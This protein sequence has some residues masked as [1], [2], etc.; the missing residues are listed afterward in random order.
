MKLNFVAIPFAALLVLLSGCGQVGATSDGGSS[1]SEG[2]AATSSAAPTS[3]GDI[4]LVPVKDPT[5]GAFTIDMPKGWKNLA[6]VARAYDQVTSVVNSVSPDGSVII[7]SGDP[8]IPIYFKTNSPTVEVAR[9]QEKVNPKIKV[10]DYI[11]AESY[12]PDY[13]TKKF[14]KLPGFEIVKTEPNADL[15]AAAIE[16][17]QKGGYNFPLETVVVHF[18]Y[19]EDGTKRNA[20]L[21]GATS[22][23]GSGWIVMC[24]GISTTGNPMDYLPVYLKMGRSS[25]TDEGWKQKQQ[26]L[27]EQRM[28][29]LKQAH[30]QQLGRWAEMNNQHQQRM[31]AIKA[32]GDA[33][34]KS[35]YERDAASDRSHRNFLNMI[36]EES[37]VVTSDGTRHQVS[38]SYD[39]YY[40]HKRTGKYIGGDV[41]FN[42]DSI[43]RMGLNPDDYEQAKVTR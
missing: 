9:F 23:M 11:P 20:I 22:D 39:N 21:L 26:A 36:N 8:A 30:Q 15:Q 33:S 4:E 40:L 13:V 38:N 5:E 24:G 17:M 14:G 10:A 12:F 31:A 34:M 3:P 16:N 6:Y 35:Y 29:A 43:R 41:H 27:H 2:G 42:E 1:P 25:V 7:F 18:R 19:D 37:T 28:A 32:F